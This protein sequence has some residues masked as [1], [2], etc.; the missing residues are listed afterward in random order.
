MTTT[1]LV[2]LAIAVGAPTKKDPPAKDPPTLV[3]EWLGESGVRGG[4]PENPPP[5]TSLTFTADG[6][7]MF[8]EGGDAKPEEG[9]YKSDPKKTPG[10]IDITPPDAPK[11][12]MLRGIYKIEGDTL[13]MCFSLRGERPTEF[14]S[15]PGTEVMLITCKRAKKE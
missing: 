11:G 13:T 5:G 9:S 15:P 4:K 3:G 1:L 7:V 10:E 8:K 14:A 2:G 6:K 12:E